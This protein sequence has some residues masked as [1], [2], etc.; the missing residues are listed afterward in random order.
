[1]HHE[2]VSK[3]GMYLDKCDESDSFLLIICR[4]D[5]FYKR[6]LQTCHANVLAEPLLNESFVPWIGSASEH[7]SFPLMLVAEA[8]SDSFVDVVL[9]P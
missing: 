6:F 1:M 5:G 3:L 4:A 9:V 2:T 8:V 7:I